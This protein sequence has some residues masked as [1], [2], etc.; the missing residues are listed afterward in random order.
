MPGANSNFLGNAIHRQLQ[1]YKDVL[2]ERAAKKGDV[3]GGGNASLE[4]HL[5]EDLTLPL[6]PRSESAGKIWT[7]VDTAVALPA[8]HCGFR[9]CNITDNGAQT[10]TCF[11]PG[12]RA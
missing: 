6:D 5:R 8:W 3:T 1:K 9:D 11:P 10:H 7:D 2:A 12:C 4:Q